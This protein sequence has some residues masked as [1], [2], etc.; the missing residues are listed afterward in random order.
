MVQPSP[1]PE[2][3]SLLT[4]AFGG[5]FRMRMVLYTTKFAPGVTESR[6]TT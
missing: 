6:G 5:G 3:T 4:T 1:L 2:F